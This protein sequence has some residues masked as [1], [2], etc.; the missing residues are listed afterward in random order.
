[1]DSPSQ[2]RAA[3]AIF[4]WVA[5]RR[6]RPAKRRAS[7]GPGSASREVAAQVDR[8]GYR[9]AD[10]R[11]AGASGAGVAKL[12]LGNQGEGFVSLGK[13]SSGAGRLN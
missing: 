10:R 6:E 7:G 5:I 9:V 4:H 8:G 12:G 2:T 13:I 11:E 1:M 3:P